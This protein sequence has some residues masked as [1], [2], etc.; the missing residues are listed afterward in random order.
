MKSPD[1]AS[2]QRHTFRKSQQIRSS[3]EYADIFEQKVRASNPCLLIYGR[4]SPTSWSR[5]GLSVSRKHGNSIRRHRLRR[6]L[7]EA[8]RL[9][10]HQLPQGYDWILIPKV[11][12]QHT[13]PQFQSALVEITS[14]IAKKLNRSR[15]KEELGEASNG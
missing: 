10:Q 11:S 5:I 6:L 14:R 2:T 12:N 8:F 4:K 3:L 1:S 7:R 13:V 9:S 15:D